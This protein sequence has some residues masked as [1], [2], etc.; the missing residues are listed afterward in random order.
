MKSYTKP[1]IKEQVIT[2]DDIIASSPVLVGG[3]GSDGKTID[4]DA[5]FN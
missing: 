1:S 5:L 2:I 3:A 4:I